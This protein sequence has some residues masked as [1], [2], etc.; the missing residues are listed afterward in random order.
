MVAYQTAYLKA[1]YPS[2]FMAAQ[3]N[4]APNI[5]KITFFMEECKRMGLDV[6]GP[7]INESQNGF[8]VSKEG[9]IRFGFGGLKGI[10]ENAIHHIIEERNK[11]GKYKSIFDLVQR[12]N[13]RAVTKK[14]LE[15]LIYSGAFD[16]FPEYH[17]SAYLYQPPGDIAGLEKITKFGAMVQSQK[18]SNTNTLFGEMEMPAIQVPTLPTCE[19]WSLT[20]RLKYEKE[21]TGMYMSGHPLDNFRFEINYYNICSIASFEE[22]K[23]DPENKE[24]SQRFRLAGL[25]TEAQHRMTKK[26]KNFA[27]LKIEDFTGNSEFF[28][29]SE[30][31][32]RYNHYLEPGTIIFIE[33]AFREGYRG[34][35]FKITKLHLLETLKTAATQ[36]LALEM[37]A[38][39]LDDK[40][41]DFLSLNF[42]QNPGKTK[43][44]MKVHDKEENTILQMSSLEHGIEMNDE[45]ATYLQK[46]KNLQVRITSL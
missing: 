12:V 1:H 35:E 46:N 5:E 19:P 43:V 32:Q 29:W 36:K 38:D 17:R 3:L 23:N 44:E 8:A 10:G 25:V 30:D 7:D 27:I 13:L 41:S 18:E 2:E 22:I 24:S 15:A 16:C 40:A 31:Y 34:V 20:E 33:G 42:Q 14:S 4:H 26:G 11:K 39:V 45:L 28:L 37:D 9:V 21:V 6:K